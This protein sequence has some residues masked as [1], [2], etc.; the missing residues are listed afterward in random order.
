[1][2]IA[3]WG[4]FYSTWGNT[5]LA[6]ITAPLML[7]AG[8]R[9]Q[10]VD[11]ATGAHAFLEAAS[12]ARRYLLTF[13]GAGHAIGFDPVPPAMR[14]SLWDISWF[15]DPVWRK[16]RVIGVS[17]HMITAFL[18]RYLKGDESRAAYLDDL[19]PDA[20]SGQ[21]QAPAGTDYGAY[22]P[23]GAGVTLWKGFQRGYAE[24][25]ELQHRDPG[26]SAALPP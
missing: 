21:W 18:D 5:G 15:E 12:G 2:A 7:I 19:V 1:M 10:T 16:E 23:G 11:Y 26:S 20:G 9:D 8:D 4:G 22:S 14:H 24:G 13:R 3:P 17:L 25:L 6:G